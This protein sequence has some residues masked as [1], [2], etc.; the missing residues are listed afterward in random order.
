MRLQRGAH[1]LGRVPSPHPVDQ[2]FGSHYLA[3]A[4]QQHCQHRTP[5]RISKIQQPSTSLDLNRPVQPELRH[6]PPPTPPGI[7]PFPA[8]RCPTPSTTYNSIGNPP[9]P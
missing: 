3:S 9:V 6:L 1:L 4:V 5:P 8:R 2:G 7:G